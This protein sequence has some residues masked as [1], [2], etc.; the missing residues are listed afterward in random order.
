MGTITSGVGLASG[1]NSREIVDQLMSIERRP[2]L[3]VERQ[4]AK[5][6]ARKAAYT[7]L[8]GRIDSLRN[9][10]TTLARPTNFRQATAASSDPDAL[11]ATASSRAAP[12]RYSVRVGRL[13]SAQQNVS[14][15]FDSPTAALSAGT[16]T[17]ELGD[18]G[19]RRTTP[20]SS[21]LGGKGITDG[22]IRITDRSEGREQFDVG[23][24]ATLEDLAAAITNSTRLDVTATVENNRLILQE[25]TNDID[26][27]FMVRDIHGDAAEKL[28]IAYNG[29]D[30]RV[31][32]DA[33]VQLGRNT[34]LDGLN[35][36]LGFGFSPEGQ[37][38]LSVRTRNGQTFTVDLAGHETLDELVTA[39]NE[40]ADGK[41]RMQI[42]AAN[43]DRLRVDDLTNPPKNIFGQPQ[44]S[45]FRIT[46]AG[47]STAANDLGIVT[48]TQSGSRIGDA[49]LAKAGSV[50]LGN[51]G[52]AT[53]Q[54]VDENGGLRITDRRGTTREINTAGGSLDDIVRKINRANFGVKARVNDAGNGLAL[55]DDSIYTG[56]I[57]VE[58]LDGTTARDLGLLGSFGLDTVAD[59]GNLQRRWISGGVR[60]EALDGGRGVGTGTFTITATDGKTAEVVIGEDVKT[61][62]DLLGTV[63]EAGAA[64]GVGLAINANGDGF[65]VTDTAGGNVGPLSVVDDDGLVAKALRIAGTAATGESTIAGS[66]E[67][68]IEVAEGDTLEDVAEKINEVDAG[69]AATVMN[70]GGLDRPYRLSLAGRNTGVNARVSFDGGTTGLSVRQVLE[71]NDAL[72]YVGGEGGAGL[73]VT[74]GTNS[75]KD[76]IPGVTLDL[77]RAGGPFGV[78]VAR[79][80][81]NVKAKLGEYVDAFNGLRESLKELTKYDPETGER[82]ALLGDGAILRVES[83]IFGLLRER[84]AGAGRFTSL[85][86]IGV[87]FG[88]DGLAFDAAKFDE[89]WAEDSESV[90]RLFSL[91]GE[92]ADGETVGL[93]L[94]WKLQ[95]RLDRLVDPADGIITRAEKTIEDKNL[96]GEDRI[97]EIDKILE[98]KRSRLEKQFY[99][100]E[101]AISRLQTQQQSLAN[102]RVYTPP[103]TRQR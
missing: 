11:T 65:V 52:G 80:T 14:R 85:S 69:L 78:T 35:D 13:A 24:Y 86:E 58:E 73:A 25:Q 6:S 87:R 1:I 23:S 92:D 34:R 71:A 64:A 70:D 41:A 21:L 4:I 12:G 88:E 8:A 95:E 47:G 62:A 93:G 90:T 28:G 36:G 54:G 38:D 3:L 46:N 76:A 26:S 22:T 98:Q 49:L 83:E 51:L 5:D 44:P 72:A 68:T 75:V 20:M 103:T 94:G 82:G 9:I 42:D 77:A 48:D 30:R 81:E 101:L 61:V 89:A 55:E 63:N 99:D 7:A 18:G 97:K 43:P 29:N 45:A 2:R 31:E 100:M 56:D 79:D 15:G 32:G 53:G 10:G 17:A 96:A 39:F 60:L 16:L 19:I 50:L 91:T 102:F 40:Q 66:Y 27:P 33:V 59:G 74:S 67:T 57:V 37:A 84:V